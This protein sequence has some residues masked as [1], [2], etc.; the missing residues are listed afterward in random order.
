MHYRVRADRDTYCTL[1][2]KTANTPWQPPPGFSIEPDPRSRFF[3]PTSVVDPLLPVPGV[4]LYAYSL[5]DLPTRDP[6]RFRRATPPSGPA[7]DPAGGQPAVSE[8][9]ATRIRLASYQEQIPPSKAEPADHAADLPSPM[10][11]LAEEVKLLPIPQEI[12]DSLP[13][14]CLILMFEFSSIRDE[15]ERTYGSPP[16]EHQRDRSRQLALEDL[17]DLALINSREFQTQKE[18]LYRA[19]LFLT[20]AS[21]DYDLKFAPTGNRVAVDYTLRD[22][23]NPVPDDSLTI[24]S[25]IEGNKVL[26]TGGN[27]VARF[28]NDIVVTFNSPQEFAADVSSRMI[29]DLSQS[30][31][32]R[33][34]VF[35]VLTQS[36]RN[37]VY[38]ARDFARYRKVLFNDLARQYYN[39]LLN[40]RTVEID[41]RDYFTQLRAF[42]R[43]QAEYR[44]GRLPRFQVDQIEQSLLSSRSRLIGDGN[45]LEQNLDLFKLQIGLPPEL[46]LHL[47][48]TELEQLTLRDEATTAT[49]RVRRAHQNLLTEQQQPSPEHGVLLNV[50]VDLAGKLLTLLELRMRLEGTPPETAAWERLRDQLVVTQAQLELRLTRFVLAQE[51][52][53]TPPA[54]P[55]RVFQRTSDVLDS[56]LWLN[57]RRLAGTLRAAAATPAVSD[58]QRRQVALRDRA[59]RLRSELE[60]A[61]AERQL[62]RIP[63]LVKD[64]DTLLADADRLAAELA[65]VL[66]IRPQ[67][68][69]E[70]Y[71]QTLT[72][73]Q[74][75]LAGSQRLLAAEVGGLTPVQIDGDEALATAL[76]LRLDLMNERGALADSWRLIKLA[77]DELKSILKLQASQQLGLRELRTHNHPVGD[78]P[79][80]DYSDTHTRLQMTLDAPLNRQAQRNVFRRS[81]IDY[82]R[83]LRN[84]LAKED[85]IKLNVR[86]DL[87]QLQVNREQYGIYVSGAAL[88]YERVVSTQLQLVLGTTKVTARD[89]VESQQAYTSALSNMA[90]AHL[91]Y[92]RTRINLFLDLELLQVNDTGFWPE[93]YDQQ[94]QPTPNYG[95]PAYASPA[96]GELPRGVH[97]SRKVRR[98]LE[99]PTGETTLFGPDGQSSSKSEPPSDV[100]PE[101]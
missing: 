73:M 76:N 66:Q 86:D 94:Y 53:A 100:L 28:A 9:A 34:I 68:E 70:E 69:Q 84:L 12:W 41:S 59:E 22:R 8:A 40:F 52:R 98:M 71:Q 54:P 16:S 67:T 99:I 55:L 63:E 27:L 74:G 56:L 30:V 65:D 11:D 95:D 87:R 97:Y 42:Y 3:D 1:E 15:Y 31:F 29:F 51:L 4:Q 96:Y 82:N 85:G 81:L 32:Q 49:E 48:L 19:A 24:P 61:V 17:V 6:N 13:S 92:L 77:A 101:P 20:L 75:L 62:D 43:A 5:P 72:R 25:A 10:L 36:E 14:S 47:D 64:S 37:V 93:V 79:D 2:Q 83:A 50:G 78:Y 44:A 90:R 18:T 21:Y 46:P 89:W 91:L 39:L 23:R 57:E 33:D 80:G 60:R 88:A 26:A 7:S 58:F 35:E 38:A 45:T